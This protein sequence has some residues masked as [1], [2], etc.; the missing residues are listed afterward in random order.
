MNLK[1]KLV[2]ILFKDTVP[3]FP[4]GK[5]TAL[6]FGCEHL[7]VLYISLCSQR[8]DDVVSIRNLRMRHAVVTRDATNMAVFLKE[9][10]FQRNLTAV[11]RN[12]SDPG[13]R[14]DTCGNHP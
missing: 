9:Y 11:K 7:L 3:V 6:F 5:P 1:I 2:V 8:R 13:V 10:N 12:F 14:N 4:L